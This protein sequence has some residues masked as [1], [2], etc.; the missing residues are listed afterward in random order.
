MAAFSSP[1]ALFAAAAASDED[2]DE[3]EDEEKAEEEE[4]EE[5][6]WALVECPASAIF[7]MPFEEASYYNKLV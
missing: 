3:D 5:E 2:E 1:A 4:E 7:T 6:E